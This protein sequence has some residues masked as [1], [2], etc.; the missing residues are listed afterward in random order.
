MGL[1]GAVTIADSPTPSLQFD[2]LD[3]ES[4]H[5]SQEHALMM[6][7]RGR[8]RHCYKY[9][10]LPGRWVRVRYDRLALLALLDRS[11]APVPQPQWPPRTGRIPVKG[12][13]SHALAQL[14]RASCSPVP[15]ALSSLEPAPAL[16][17]L[18]PGTALYPSPDSYP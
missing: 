9:W 10:L 3:Q 14:P 11:V 15:S 1:G 2:L 4:L 6:E 17:P 16:S 7:E 13:V 8:P 18:E 5:E 12:P